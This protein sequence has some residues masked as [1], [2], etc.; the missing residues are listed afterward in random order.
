MT[1]I[2]QYL[3]IDLGEK[4]IGLATGDSLTKM[5]LPFKTVANFSELLEL[6]SEDEIEVVVLGAPRKMSGEDANSKLWL[7]FVQ[8]LKS[9][10][11]F[12]LILQDERLSSKGADA[13]FGSKKDKA[14][15]DE[16][17]AAIILQSFFDKQ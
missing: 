4:R 2:K 16:N 1:H 17:A 8:K 10:T 3:G 15:R 7:Q 5:A 14:S 9:Q 6:I 13:L 11:N 12:K